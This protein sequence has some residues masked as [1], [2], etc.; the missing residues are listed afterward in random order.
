MNDIFEE[1]KISYYLYTDIVNNM[2]HKRYYYMDTYDY[3]QTVVDDVCQRGNL[4]ES[5]KIYWEEMLR[6]VHFTSV[7]SIIRNQK[8]LEGIIYGVENKNLMIFSSSLRGFLEATTDSY[9]SLKSVPTDISINFKNIKKALGGELNNFFTSGKLEDK[10]IHFEYASKKNNKRSATVYESLSCTKYI[11]YFDRYNKLGIKKLYSVL[12]EIA[13]PAS[14]S[15][16]CFT[17]KTI[18]SDNYEYITTS[19]ES[20]YNQVNNII[21]E[22]SNA[23][24]NLVKISLTLSFTCLKI[25]NLYDFKDVK[26]DYIEKCKFNNLINKKGWENILKMKEQGAKYKS[27]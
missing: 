6:R 24:R 26:S 21:V 7:T 20:D 23:I 19:N 2:E 5:T 3:M 4:C 1:L 8:W 27:K 12:C 13:H 14:K 15:V 22:Y 25:L 11:E 18:V 10:L 16:S 9:Y 17:S